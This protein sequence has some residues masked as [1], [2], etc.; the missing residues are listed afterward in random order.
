M[1]I[2]FVHNQGIV[3]VRETA[4]LMKLSYQNV[5]IMMGQTLT[6]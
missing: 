4:E 6:F 2:E 5:K 1:A 3:A